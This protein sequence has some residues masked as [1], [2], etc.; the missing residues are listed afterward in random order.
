MNYKNE[1]IAVLEKIKKN[2][3]ESINQAKRSIS[4]AQS[5]ANYHVGAM[6]SRY[7]TFKEEAQYL[8]TAQKIRLIE[9]E[10][11]FAQ[12]EIIIKKILSESFVFKKVELGALFTVS[13][14]DGAKSYFI[15]P[16]STGEVE[17]L[18][19]LDVFCI[20]M[21]AP[22]IKKY[23]GLVEGDEPEDSDK[24]EYIESIF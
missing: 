22:V 7:D 10:N 8:A 1:K 24:E 17:K 19:G 2:L 5:E 21:S 15:V 9:L 11:S 3:L 14:S 20:N 6:Q 23:I 4:D 18:C 16:T 13:S 12:C